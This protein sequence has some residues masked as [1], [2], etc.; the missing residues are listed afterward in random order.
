MTSAKPAGSG[1]GS[2]AEAA[3]FSPEYKARIV[4]E[5]DAAPKNEMGA[6]L[7]RERLYHSHVKE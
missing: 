5:C 2:P 6:V 7:C 4:A 1:P 3:H